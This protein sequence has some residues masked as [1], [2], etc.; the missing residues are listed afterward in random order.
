MPYTADGSLTWIFQCW[1][2]SNQKWEIVNAQ[3]KAATMNRFILEPTPNSQLVEVGPDY[4]ARTARLTY[5]RN[6]ELRFPDGRCLDVP[7]SA[8]DRTK[9]VAHPCHGGK[10]QKW[11]PRDGQIVLD[12]WYPLACLTLSANRYD[13]GTLE[14]RPCTM[15]LPEQRFKLP[16]AQIRGDANKCLT[17]QAN[18][19]DWQD[20]FVRTC[21]SSREQRWD[22]DMSVW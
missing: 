9:V 1:G 13:Y 20:V 16:G 7:W 17:T 3:V 15:R 22:I 8:R 19:Q 12:W 18:P 11:H 4:L 21:D 14:I 6:N 5:T 10:N 2:G